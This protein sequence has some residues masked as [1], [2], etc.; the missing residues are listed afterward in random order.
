MAA[1]A[2]HAILRSLPLT[3]N[4][5]GSDSTVALVAQP[6]NV[7]HVQ[8]AGVLRAVRRMACQAAFRFDRG[9]LVDKGPTHVRVALGADHALI[10]RGSQVAVLES[11]VNIVAVTALDG[12]LVHRV[13]EGHIELSFLVAVTLEAER[14]LRSLEQR[15]LFAAVNAVATD[16][17]DISFGMRRAIEVGMRACMAAQTLGVDVFGRS[18]GGIEDLGHVATA[19]HVLTARAMAVLA[20]N[21]IRVPVHQLHLLVRIGGETLGHVRVTGGAG[22]GADELGMAGWRGRRSLSL[23][24]RRGSCQRRC[25]QQARTQQKHQKHSQSRPFPGS[26]TIE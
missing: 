14:G 10:C 9:V 18:L 2:R 21:A 24:S 23:G 22:V 5:A 19:G 25:A 4:R 20:G 3:M 6:V 7:R 13:V 11:A 15:L 16:A 8:H 26:R 1:G 12:A 17:A